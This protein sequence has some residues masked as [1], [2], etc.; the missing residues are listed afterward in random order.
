MSR[1]ELHVIARI[2]LIG[3][4][5]YIFLSIFLNI[6][7]SFASLPFVPSASR[8]EMSIWVPIALGIYAIVAA[9]AVYF[10][11]RCAN[12]F[13]DKIAGAEPVDDTQVSWLA[14]AFRLVCVT[15]GVLFI[16]WSVPQLMVTVFNYIMNMNNAD[17]SGM[18][19]MYIGMS[20]ITEIIK[21]IIMLGIGIYMAYGAPAFVSWQVKMTLKQCGKLVEQQPT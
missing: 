5:L 6:L 7:S 20:S 17:K 10:L 1:N 11:V 21:Y 9:A 19:T 15:T 2:V 12:Q 18:R 8:M 16:Y 14:V 3:T 4:G 13:S